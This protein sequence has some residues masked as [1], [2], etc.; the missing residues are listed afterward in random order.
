M[1][2]AGRVLEPEV[3]GDVTHQLRTGNLRNTGHDKVA[4]FDRLL[5]DRNRLV[6]CGHAR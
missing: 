3:L 2:G 1:V 4:A 6:A 5:I